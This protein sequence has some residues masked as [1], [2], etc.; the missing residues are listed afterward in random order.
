[1]ITPINLNRVRKV[2][3]KALAKATAAKNRARFGRSKAAKA[4]D[5][6]A[7]LKAKTLLDQAKRDPP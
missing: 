7:E 3:R 5:A 2:R 6:A 4:M 1:M